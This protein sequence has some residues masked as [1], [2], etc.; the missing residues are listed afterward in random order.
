MAPT[1]PAPF[2][3]TLHIG[4]GGPDVAAYQLM[5]HNFT[6]D[7]PK[8][9]VRTYGISPDPVHHFGYFGQPMAAQVEHFR[10]LH[11]AAHPLDIIGAS[12]GMIGPRIHRAL[13]RW[14]GPDAQALLREQWKALHPESS[15]GSARATAV[16][17][18]R[19]W[20]AHRGVSTYS[21]PG[22]RTIGRRW[23]GI[24]ARRMPPDFPRYSD[25]SAGNTWALWVAARDHAAVVHD[26]SENGWAWGSTLSMAP[27]G[28]ARTAS[29]AQPG[30]LFFYGRWAGLTTHVAM[31]AERVNG[32]PW[33]IGFGQQGGP[34][35]LPYRYR[36]D[37]V[38]IRSYFWD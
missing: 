9:R 16:H 26:P 12:G 33:V 24:E 36:H 37:L 8:S 20:Y 17:A 5:L 18:M 38:L 22:H 4:M 10:Q 25:C 13:V 11:N 32:V 6:L 35:Y 3:R 29:S 7:N 14:V 2:C 19:N 1:D 31:M 23:D 21:G 27:H 34:S 28:Q 30:D 15:I